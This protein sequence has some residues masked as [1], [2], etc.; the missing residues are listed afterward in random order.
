MLGCAAGGM[1]GEEGVG[2]AG[3]E[4]VGMSYGCGWGVSI[5]EDY[6][7]VARGCG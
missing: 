4:G 7:G 1:T 5:K 2:V 6:M 3:E